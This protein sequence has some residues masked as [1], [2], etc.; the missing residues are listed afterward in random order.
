MFKNVGILENQYLGCELS[1]AT[2]PCNGGVQD[3][4]VTDINMTNQQC[5]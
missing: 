3:P 2:R 1:C 4:G 5:L